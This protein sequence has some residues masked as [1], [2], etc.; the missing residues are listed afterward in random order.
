MKSRGPTPDDLS[1]NYRRFLGICRLIDGMESDRAVALI[2]TVINEIADRDK[3]N[4]ARF[5]SAIAKG[6]HE[7][8]R[9]MMRRAH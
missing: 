8:A 5:W 9:A 1:D 4:A 3:E 6:A 2:M 7:E